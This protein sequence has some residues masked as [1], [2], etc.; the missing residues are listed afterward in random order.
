MGITGESMFSD[1]R[2]FTSADT[3]G[4][5]YQVTNANGG[6]GR[7][8]TKF[9]II[10]NDSALHNVEVRL[11]AYNG[12]AWVTAMSK[13]YSV[14]AGETLVAVEFLAPLL[15]RTDNNHSRIMVKIGEP[16]GSGK[17]VHVFCSGAQ[18]V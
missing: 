5:Y 10:N 4:Q 11:E 2:N 12:A 1:F 14:A 18:F 17:T 7:S 16:V 15:P 6:Y 13:P 3:V 9:D 8:V